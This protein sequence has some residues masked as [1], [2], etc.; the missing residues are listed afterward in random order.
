MVPK[1]AH[2][3]SEFADAVKLEVDGDFAKALP[4]L[5]QA[6][7][8]AGAARPLR[9]VLPGLRRT[10]SR[11]RRRTRARRSRRLQP[12]SPVGYLAEAAALREAECDEAL[13]DQAAAMRGLRAAVEDARRRRPTK[14]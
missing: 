10:A 14:C 2:R 13:G 4:I 6:V 1:G 5:S 11:A 7:A 8:A 12:K 9:A 3:T